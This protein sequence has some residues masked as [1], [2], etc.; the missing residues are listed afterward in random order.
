MDYKSVSI[1]GGGPSGCSAGIFLAKKGF[2]N[3]TI[4]ERAPNKRKGCAGGISW[5]VKRYKELLRDIPLNP[6]KYC[7]FDFDGVKFNYTFKKPFSYVMDRLIFDKNLMEIAKSYD[8]KLI[9][10]EA[11]IKKLNNSIIIDARGF[12]KSEFIASSI[13]TICKFK[14]SVLTMVFNKK[15]NPLGFFW[16]FPLSE[17][18]ANVGAYGLTKEWRVPIANAFE[19]FIKKYKLKILEKYASPLSLDGGDSVLGYRRNDSVVLKVGEAARLVN[20][21]SGE[22]IYYGI[23]S[24]E[25]ASNA[26]LDNDPVIAYSQSVKENIL[27]EFSHWKTAYRLLLPLPPRLRVI[28]F[29]FGLSFLNRVKMQG[30]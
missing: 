30:L 20:P 7:E 6:M 18:Y 21:I 3:I 13:S 10:K 29:K 17:E 25:L 24:S 5:R 23:R 15:I 8:I 1:V 4:Y 26:L 2:K 14:N 9:R 12:V 16:I 11:D 19:T 22:G 28:L 27:D